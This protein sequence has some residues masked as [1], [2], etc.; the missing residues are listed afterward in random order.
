MRMRS[1]VAALYQKQALATRCFHL[2]VVFQ[3]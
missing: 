2:C 1:V 3:Q